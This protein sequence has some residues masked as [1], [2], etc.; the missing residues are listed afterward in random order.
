MKRNIMITGWIL[1][2][3]LILASTSLHAAENRGAGVPS[4]ALPE[5]LKGL[6]IRDYFVPSPNKKVGVIHALSEDG[7]VVVIHRATREAYFGKAGDPVH[8][9][10]SINT[11]A[12]SRCRIRF[13]NGDVVSMAANTEFSVESYQDQKKVGKK[14]SLFSMFKGKAMFYA[15][16]LFKYKETR[17]R[18]KT[19]TAV[20]GV[21]GTKFGAHVYWVKEEKKADAGVRVADNSNGIGSYLAQAGAG[22]DNVAYGD[23]HSEDGWLDIVVDGQVVASV[24]PGE[25][26][27]TATGVVGITPEGY[28]KLFDKAVGIKPEGEEAYVANIEDIFILTPEQVEILKLIEEHNDTNQQQS[29]TQIEDLTT[30]PVTTAGPPGGQL[31]GYFSAML[32]TKPNGTWEVAEVYVTQND[33]GGINDLSVD[34]SQGDAIRTDGDW[35]KWQ[36]SPYHENGEYFKINRTI[37]NGGGGAAEYNIDVDTTSYTKGFNAWARWGWWEHAATFTR[38]GSDYR[39]IHKSWWIE[40]NQTLDSVIEAKKGI[41]SFSGTSS[42]TYADGTD[43]SG[44][45]SCDINYGASNNH[46]SN[47]QL[48]ALGGDKGARI[49]NG[50]GSLGSSRFEITN[51]TFQL[52][53]GGG[54]NNSNWQECHG[55]HY[56]LNG[57]A[58]GG[59]WGMIRDEDNA[60]WG[61]FEATRP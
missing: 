50:S 28:K 49:Q 18:L 30:M 7:H 14:T 37:P 13:S 52:K 4:Q 11:L 22:S 48:E 41:M 33:K 17:F 6:E 26:Y 54:W 42:G 44:T 1:L 60:A 27:R 25:W 47:F 36:G 24:P 61:V 40:G 23:F 19:P 15:M 59:A 46:V 56:G 45:V 32:Q 51:G 16:R 34:P 5:E 8:E 2:L 58:I 29:G 9:N 53:N 57:Q 20:V 39:M 55:T 35:I 3:S 12:D 10:D 43:L 38:G 31:H 21:R